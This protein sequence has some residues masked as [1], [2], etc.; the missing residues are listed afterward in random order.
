MGEMDTKRIQQ[1]TG[2]E[3]TKD[4][5]MGKW[6]QMETRQEKIM[7]KKKE[8]SRARKINKYHRKGRDLRAS[9]GPSRWTRARKGEDATKSTTRKARWNEEPGRIVVEGGRRDGGKKKKGVVDTKRKENRCEM[10]DRIPDG[11]S[12]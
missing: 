9:Q 2:N 5:K 4:R 6:K 12:Q 7:G 3:T 1:K 8:G 11:K 10:K